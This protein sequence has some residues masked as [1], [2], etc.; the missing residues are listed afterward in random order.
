MAENAVLAALPPFRGVT[1]KLILVM[2]GACIVGALLMAV[3]PGLAML[4]MDKVVLHPTGAIGKLPWQLLTYVFASVQPFNTLFACLSFWFFGSAL[5]DERGSK[6][7]GEFFCLSVAGGAIVAC[8][9]SRIVFP[10]SFALGPGNVASGAWAFVL[11]TIVAYARLNPEV[12]LNFNFIFRVKAKYM[13][14]IYVA[15]YLAMI[16]TSGHQFDAM[17]TLCVALVGYLF[18]TL[19][20]RRGL[21]FLL[22]ERAYGL[23][24][25][26]YRRKRQQAAKK[27]KVYMRKQ[28]KEVSLDEQGQYLPLDQEKRDPRDS[29]DRSWMN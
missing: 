12:V 5:E 16:L 17:L 2:A 4:L 29:K 13:A 10:T 21:R 9:I 3:I 1:R 28:G 7:M 19:V 27:F 25:A 24:N 23:R 15:V 6:W 8:L 11:A 26:Y 20:P 22:L 18:L 14:V